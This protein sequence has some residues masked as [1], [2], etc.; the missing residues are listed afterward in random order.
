METYWCRP[1]FA[2]VPFSLSVL[3]ATP[4][5]SRSSSIR[6]I[7]LFLLLYR[8]TPLLF[9]LHLL[10][11]SLW[12]RS[13]AGT[14]R[15]HD[16]QSG[17]D[18]PE[19]RLRRAGTKRPHDDQSATDLP[20][21][22]LRRVLLD[23]SYAATSQ[24]SSVGDELANQSQEDCTTGQQGLPCAILPSPSSGPAYTPPQIKAPEIDTKEVKKT[25][26]GEALFNAFGDDKNGEHD[27]LDLQ[28]D[29]KQ[30]A[31]KAGYLVL[32]WGFLAGKLKTEPGQLMEVNAKKV[33]KLD[34]SQS[35]AEGMFQLPD[36]W[37]SLVG[38]QR[39]VQLASV[40][41]ENDPETTPY[42]ASILMM[43]ITS[44]EKFLISSVGRMSLTDL[45]E[46]IKKLDDSAKGF[47][48]EVKSLL[49]NHRS[50]KDNRP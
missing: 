2:C 38:F 29:E 4:H 32:F 17:T 26:P 36:D 15:P 40:T 25:A 47:F 43:D 20:E 48:E 37:Y 1:L 8:P 10:F 28:G 16:D 44:E 41:H 42:F 34:F 45:E 22:R 14:K 19:K 23:H 13:S 9:P 33:D 35:P 31:L 6:V 5:C 50:T 21:K 27:E 12:V 24:A 46:S 11:A 49:R 30:K 3:P 18:L 7:N 39:S